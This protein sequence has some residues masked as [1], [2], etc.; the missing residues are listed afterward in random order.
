MQIAGP[1]AC[2]PWT[3]SINH[4]GYGQFAIDTKRHMLAHRFAY[5]DLI[6]P[7]PDGLAL[8][9]LCRNRQ[10]VNPWH[11][12]PV[13]PAINNARARTAQGINEGATQP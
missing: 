2:W 11:L 10:C 13:T 7:V 4:G 6:G 3:A 12:D 9:H 8:D 1:E 5:E